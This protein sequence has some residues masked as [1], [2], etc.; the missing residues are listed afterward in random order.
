VHA[1]L[2]TIF[3]DQSV[4]AWRPAHMPAVHQPACAWRPACPY[5][6]QCTSLLVLGNLP[7]HMHCSATVCL[8]WA[9][10]LPI[11]TAVSSVGTGGTITGIGEFL[12]SQNPDIKVGC[13]PIRRC[14]RYA[15]CRTRETHGCRRSAWLLASGFVCSSEG[16]GRAAAGSRGYPVMRH[17]SQRGQPDGLCLI[18]GA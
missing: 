15:L 12:K 17:K 10:C 18:V 11:C 16:R 7:A 2:H 1:S 8:C 4:C 14:V 6:L 9:T 5:A 3:A 13:M